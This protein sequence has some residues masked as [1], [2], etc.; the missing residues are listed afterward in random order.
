[1]ADKP[2]MHPVLIVILAIGFLSACSPKI[3]TT[4]LWQP[5]AAAIDKPATWQELSA[6]NSESGI[7][8]GISNDLH[9]VYIHLQIDKPET[10]MKVLRAGMELSIDTLG[11]KKGHC[12]IVFPEPQDRGL[13][14]GGGA[15]RMGG[16]GMSPEGRR[17]SGSTQVDR[18]GDQQ[19]MLRHMI[20]QKDRMRLTGFKNHPNGSLP[21]SNVE[22]IMV[23][24]ELD[25]IGRL[26]YRAIIPLNTF[27]KSPITVSDA[28]KD[29]SLL[30]TIK[31]IDMPGGPP[32]GMARGTGNQGGGGMTGRPTGGRPTGGGMPGD[33]TQGRTMGNRPGV[34][35]WEV[36]IKL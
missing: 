18:S 29:F 12:T 34:R 10:R 21:L 7:G 3:R 14:A 16:G 30:I 19:E 25:T 31:G 15:T 26:S 32:A 22:G 24:L 9:H 28:N 23:S 36:I 35:L 20:D 8:Y 1:M 33:M 13:F 27:Y 17:S 5:S 11:K 4:S 2:I 6:Y